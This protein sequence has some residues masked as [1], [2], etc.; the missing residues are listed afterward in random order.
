MLVAGKVTREAEA[1]PGGAACAAK[2]AADA[3]TCAAAEAAYLCGGAFDVALFGSW[4][5]PVRGPPSW[6]MKRV[7][8]E[9]TAVKVAA[10]RQG[11]R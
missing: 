4:M 6:P 7:R 5:A 1:G 10:T 11:R 3:L 2:V 8:K 9:P